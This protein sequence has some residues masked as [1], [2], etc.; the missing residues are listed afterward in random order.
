MSASKKFIV[1]DWNGTLLD[2]T[3]AVLVAVNA[4]FSEFKRPPLSM[5]KFRAIGDRPFTKLYASAGFNEAEIQSIIT[6]DRQIFHDHYETQAANATLRDGATDI[7]HRL[8]A[9]NVSNLIVSNHLTNKIINLLHKHDIHPYFDEVIAYA[10]AN[11]QMKGK[12]KGEKLHQHIKE[13]GL[14]AAN[15]IIIGDTIEEIEIARKLGMAS[16]AIT[17]GDYAENRLREQNPDHLIHSLPELTRI[18]EEREFVV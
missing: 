13:T 16:I 9:N 6:I 10:C 1:W 17:G 8:R 18:L 5:E 14:T 11:T 12:S 2:D 7:L 15:A 3:D 4:I